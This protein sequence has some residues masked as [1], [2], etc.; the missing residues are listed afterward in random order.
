MSEVH[1]FFKPEFINRVDEIIVF[2]ALGNDVL[3]QIAEKFLAQLRNRLKDHD[4]N[5]TVSDSALKRI[6]ACGVDPLYGARPMK[7]HIQCEIETAVAKVILENPDINGKTIHV[8]AN[9]DQYI[10]TVK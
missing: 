7:R 9:D 3:A 6:I 5:L 10:V 2:N 1:K 8:D 4:I